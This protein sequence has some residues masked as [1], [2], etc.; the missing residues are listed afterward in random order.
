MKLIVAML[1]LGCFYNL[2]MPFEP[3]LSAILNWVIIVLPIAHIIEIFIFKKRIDNAPG[4]NTQH[5]IQTFIF[6]AAHILRL[7]K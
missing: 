4:D 3:N 5:Y 6:G 2:V 1:W 7:P